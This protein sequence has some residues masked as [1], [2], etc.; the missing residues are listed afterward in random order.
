MVIA[1]SFGRA[2]GIGVFFKSCFTLGNS[3]IEWNPVRF[4]QKEASCYLGGLV[5]QQSIFSSIFYTTM[6]LG[7]NAMNGLV[8]NNF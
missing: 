2:N 4:H 7:G 8:E 3:H 6:N 1:L 5:D